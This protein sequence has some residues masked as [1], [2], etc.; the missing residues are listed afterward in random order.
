MESDTRTSTLGILTSRKPR[1]WAAGRLLHSPFRVPRGSS[2]TNLQ[3]I[4]QATFFSHRWERMHRVHLIGRLGPL[5]RRVHNR[6]LGA[7]Q[8][9]TSPC[10]EIEGCLRSLGNPELTVVLKVLCE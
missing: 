2:S 4:S 6:V 3:R 1:A 8:T 5:A 10:Q 7:T 9:G